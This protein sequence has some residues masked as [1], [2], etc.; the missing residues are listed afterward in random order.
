MQH[1]GIFSFLSGTL[2]AVLATILEAVNPVLATSAAI[3]GLAG[4]VYGLWLKHIQSEREG[5]I[6]RLEI[7]RRKEELK[8]LKKS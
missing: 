2:G 6:H 5:E 8:D 7:Q 3:V 4:A 1:A